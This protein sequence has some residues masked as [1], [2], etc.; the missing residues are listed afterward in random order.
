MALTENDKHALASIARAALSAAVAGGKHFAPDDPGL[1]NLLEKRGCF[2]TLKTNNRLRGCLGCFTSEQ[3]LY[4]TV[5]EYTRFS[6]LDDPRFS[7][8]RIRE[9]ELPAVAIDVSCL[10]PLAPCAEPENITLGMHGIYV[11][12]GM[13]SGCFLPQV[14]TETGWNVEEFW[15]HCCRDKAGL[16]WDAWRRPEVECMTFTADVFDA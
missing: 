6:A 12:S 10:T 5:A 1:P 9:D 11:R 14:A 13:R 8:Q 15:G 16:D 2:V 4:R 7:G 3:P